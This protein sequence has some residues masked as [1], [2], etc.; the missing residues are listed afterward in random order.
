[1][2]KGRRHVPRI[3]HN[4]TMSLTQFRFEQSEAAYYVLTDNRP[5]VD[6]RGIKQFVR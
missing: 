1:M 3:L 6:L 2:P 4:M 5:R